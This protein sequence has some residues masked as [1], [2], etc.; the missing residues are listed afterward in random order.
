MSSVS[1]EDVKKLKVTELREQLEARNLDTSGLKPA[2][3]KRLEEALKKTPGTT[4][5]TAPSSAGKKEKKAASTM[6]PTKT[7]PSSA[8][9]TPDGKRRVVKLG[10]ASTA[11]SASTSSTASPASTSSS[12]AAPGNATTPKKIPLSGAGKED[13]VISERKRRADKFGVPMKLSEDEK[14]S[15]RQKRFSGGADGSS[16]LFASALSARPNK[17]QKLTDGADLAGEDPTKLAARAKKFAVAPSGPAVAAAD[18]AKAKARE[19]RFATNKVT[20]SKKVSTKS[21]TSVT[22]VKKTGG[23]SNGTSTSGPVATTPVAVAA[24]S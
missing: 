18:E 2:L 19:G 24:A 16:A 10:S 15:V 1:V 8:G 6:T 7:A 5:A 11:P 4:S 22:P 9:N 20:P 14:A 23:N 17:R 12:P 3:V 21:A 13:S